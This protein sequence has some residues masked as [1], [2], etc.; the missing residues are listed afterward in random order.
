MMT[1]SMLLLIALAVACERWLKAFRDCRHERER[2]QAFFDRN[3]EL[4]ADNGR[5][6]TQNRRL[7]ALVTLAEGRGFLAPGSLDQPN[8]A[9]DFVRPYSCYSNARSSLSVRL[10]GSLGPLGAVGPKEG[11]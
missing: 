11:M 1:A 5:L 2:A 10:E 8:D 9:P 3:R 4:S 7:A 6:Y